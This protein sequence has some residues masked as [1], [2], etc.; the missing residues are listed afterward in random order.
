M[1]EA[2]EAWG[3]GDDEEVGWESEIVLVMKIV[4]ES[5][6]DEELESGESGDVRELLHGEFPEREYP[7]IWMDSVR[8]RAFWDV[9]VKARDDEEEQG[10]SCLAYRYRRA[11]KRMIMIIL[12]TWKVRE[13]MAMVMAMEELGKEKRDRRKVEWRVKDGEMSMLNFEHEEV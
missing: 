11:W 6:R 2:V 1:W 10:S 3:L 5:G 13:V 12:R 7:M 4:W 9:D 8:E